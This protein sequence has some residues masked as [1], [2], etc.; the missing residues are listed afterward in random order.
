MWGRG[1]VVFFLNVW[2]RNAVMCCG[3]MLIVA[4][5]VKFIL[6]PRRLMK[7]PGAIPNNWGNNPVVLR[8]LHHRFRLLQLSPA[9]DI[10]AMLFNDDRHGRHYSNHTLPRYLPVSF[11]LCE[12]SDVST[13]PGTSSGSPLHLE[14][15]WQEYNLLPQERKTATTTYVELDIIMAPTF[16][17][18]APPGTGDANSS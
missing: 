6:Q 1:G 15:V 5:K 16:K 7:A 11:S 10:F 3:L 2:L 14:P 13:R 8:Y 9:V 4:M 18:F 17:S 12:K